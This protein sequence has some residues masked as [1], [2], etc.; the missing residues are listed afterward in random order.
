GVL[1]EALQE[2]HIR[3]QQSVAE[4]VALHFVLRDREE[5]VGVVRIV[6]VDW[7]INCVGGW[8]AFERIT[9]PNRAWGSSAIYFRAC[10]H[11]DRSTAAPNP[12]LTKITVHCVFFDMCNAFLD[13]IQTCQSNH[14]LRGDHSRTF[15]RPVKSQRTF[16]QFVGGELFES[17][18]G[19]T[20]LEEIEIELCGVGHGEASSAFLRMSHSSNFLKSSKPFSACSFRCSTSS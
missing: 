3:I 12:C 19:E 16:G 6:G 8:K 15:H 14:C 10:R 1:E 7:V 20:L 4:E 2:L 5:L 13:V 17:T 18:A 9:N 11:E